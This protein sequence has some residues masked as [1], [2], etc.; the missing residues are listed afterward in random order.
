M[1]KII[2]GILCVQ[3]IS[4]QIP[5]GKKV[6]SSLYLYDLIEKKST[7]LTTENRHFEAPNW[8]PNGTYLLINSGGKI[9]KYSIKGEKIQVLDTGEIS[10]CNNDHGISF[11][12]R[13]LFISSGKNEIKEHSSF[14]YKMPIQGGI[15]ELLT[16]LSPSYWHGVSPDGKDIVYCAAR[17][18][19]YDVYKMSSNG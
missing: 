18:G 5:E 10:K 17:N 14:I 11:D 9:E 13:T 16:P 4:A 6:I 1:K 15:P 8:A 7:L 19:N 2:I 12:G 3:F